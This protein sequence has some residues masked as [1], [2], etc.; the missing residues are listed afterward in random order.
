MLRQPPR[1]RTAIKKKQVRV[2]QLLCLAAAH[3]IC[4]RRGLCLASRSD[5]V[6]KKLCWCGTQQ[7]AWNSRHPVHPL[8]SLPPVR[9]HSVQNCGVTFKGQPRRHGH[10]RHASCQMRRDVSSEDSALAQGYVVRAH[11]LLWRRGASRSTANHCLSSSKE[12]IRRTFSRASDCRSV[13]VLCHAHAPVHHAILVYAAVCR[14]RAIHTLHRF[15]PGPVSRKR[16]RDKLVSLTQ[17]SV[18]VN[19][20][21]SIHAGCYRA[22]RKDYVSCSGTAP[23]DRMARS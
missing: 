23:A 10:G 17:L 7:P 16:S 12:L 3:C 21:C 14:R 15:Q 5:A 18:S 9:S 20:L 19:L 2:P 13:V 22:Q 8:F 4:P 1:L 11:V 6:G